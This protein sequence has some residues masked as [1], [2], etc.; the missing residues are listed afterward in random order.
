M[1]SQMV[2][3]L[4]RDRKS[5]LI[6]LGGG[7][8]A[9]FISFTQ[10][11]DSN[12]FAMVYVFAMITNASWKP[13]SA[14]EKSLPLTFV[15]RLVGN[16]VFALAYAIILLVPVILSQNDANMGF[17]F[18]I[19]IYLVSLLR[20]IVESNYIR[21][22]PIT[23]YSWLIAIVYAFI[24]ILLIFAGVL[25]FSYTFISLNLLVVVIY[26]LLKETTLYKSRRKEYGINIER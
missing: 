20:T 19:C 23:D 10:S 16:M 5:L 25:D 9:V 7:I 3:N 26:Q 17:D 11:Q 14:F 8:A 15:E 2:L 6:H 4:N 24:V 1:M 22:T 21:K 18:V 13:I 12:P